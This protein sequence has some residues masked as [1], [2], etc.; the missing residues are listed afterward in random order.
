MLRIVFSLTAASRLALQR[1]QSTHTS[2]PGEART[3]QPTQEKLTLPDYETET[4]FGGEKS[5]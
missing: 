3:P 1:G 5:R 4:E 2:G